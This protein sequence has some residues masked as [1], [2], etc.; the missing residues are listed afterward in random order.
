MTEMEL[1]SL[2]TGTNILDLGQKDFLKDMVCMS[3]PMATYTKGTG[4]WVKWKGVAPMST[5]TVTSTLA[6]GKPARWK[7][8]VTFIG[9]YPE[10]LWTKDCLKGIS[11]EVN[12]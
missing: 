10:T 12:Q 9:T 5:I 11:K 6:C 4:C 3:S 7:D 2:R 1:F 8:V